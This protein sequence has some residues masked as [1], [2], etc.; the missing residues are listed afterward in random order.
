MPT[1]P[2]QTGGPQVLLRGVALSKQYR[3]GGWLSGRSSPVAALHT[4]DFTIRAGSTLALIGASGSGKSTLARC[5]ACLEKPDSGEIWFAGKDLVSLSQREL[6]AFRRQIQ[7]IFQE[8]AASLNPRFTAVQ[9]VSEPLLIA[10][11]GTKKERQERAIELMALV[12]LPAGLASRLPFEFSGGQRRRLA[13]AR[14]LALEPKL[15]ILDEALTGLDL[16]TRAQISNLLLQLQEVYSL[17]YLCISHDLDL[18]THLAD[19][20]V[21]LREGRVVEDLAP[22]QSVSSQSSQADN[23]LAVALELSSLP[24]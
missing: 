20:V 14:A 3:R 16:S 12:G 15:L 18:V 5:L 8:P 6:A 23:P 7:L 13:I 10:G 9:I 19:D 11:R 1:D 21:I 17:T 4:V 2:L 24:G 22:D